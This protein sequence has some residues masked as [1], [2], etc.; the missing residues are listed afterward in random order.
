VQRACRGAAWLARILPWPIGFSVKRISPGFQVMLAACS[1]MQHRDPSEEDPTA[2]EEALEFDG[3]K[4]DQLDDSYRVR[5]VSASENGKVEHDD[6]GQARWKWTTE[7]NSPAPSDTGTFDLLKSLDNAALDVSP[8][9][10]DDA[11][12][13]E[14]VKIDKVAGY[15]PYETLVEREPSKGF[16]TKRNAKPRK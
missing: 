5:I 3:S 8:P 15:N 7:T 9:A 14:P 4:T 1:R 12:V 16:A 13:P 11:A 10:A 2:E 6:R